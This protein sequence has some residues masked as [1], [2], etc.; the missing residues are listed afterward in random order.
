MPT[1]FFFLPTLPNVQFQPR[2]STTDTTTTNHQPPS[3]SLQTNKKKIQKKNSN[4]ET[5]ARVDSP[6]FCSKKPQK[7]TIFEKNITCQKYVQQKNNIVS[8]QVFSY[9][10]T[11]ITINLQ[12][13][14]SACCN[15][16]R[17]DSRVVPRSAE[18]A[19]RRLLLDA[20]EIHSAFANENANHEPAID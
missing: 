5:V 8:N 3:L 11:S 10:I 19:A 6:F 17:A 15:H 2:S 12:S 4:L 9:M 1:F 14:C 16:K 13:A 7:K 18:N 20:M